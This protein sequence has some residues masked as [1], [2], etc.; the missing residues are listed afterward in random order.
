MN[1][2]PFRDRY[3]AMFLET[4][5]SPLDW[6]LS[7]SVSFLAELTAEDCAELPARVEPPIGSLHTL[8]LF[9]LKLILFEVVSGIMNLC[10]SDSAFVGKFLAECRSNYV[11]GDD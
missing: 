8:R 9:N 3:F 4:G 2:G 10:L 5:S 7:F 6:T 1:F 11:F